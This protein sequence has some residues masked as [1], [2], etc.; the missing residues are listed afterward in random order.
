[1]ASAPNIVV[2][3]GPNG[4]GK[5]T[6][7]RDVLV[8]ALRVQEFVNADTIAAGLAAFNPESAAF[9][10]GRIMLARLHELAE[11]RSTFA[12]ESTLASRSFAP[13]LTQQAKTG[14]G[15]H[16]VYVALKSPELAVRRVARRVREGGHAIPPDT[17]KR[18]FFRSATNLLSL[19]LPLAETWRIYDN[20]AA[21]PTLVASG[22]LG[23]ASKIFVPRIW[24][25][26][27]DAAA[28][29]T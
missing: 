12:F 13:W 4:A 11:S 5:S 15:V 20:S 2:I 1:M 19:Y 16:V 27:H 28:K 23:A 21:V 8:D 25:A 22:G 26:I 6:I 18:R 14:Y 10:A 3:G 17:I 24:N 29:A 7:A 9:A